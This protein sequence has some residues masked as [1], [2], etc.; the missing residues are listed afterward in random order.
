MSAKDDAWP[1]ASEDSC[2]V[3]GEVS[4]CAF[5]ALGNPL[6]H[7]KPWLPEHADNYERDDL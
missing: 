4:A 7:G 2:E 3:C 5:D 1:P 6:V